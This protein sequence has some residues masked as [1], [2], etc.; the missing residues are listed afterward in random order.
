MHELPLDKQI[1]MKVR[2]LSASYGQRMIIEEICLDIAEREVI[3]LTGSNGSGK[4]T[5]L[6]ALFGLHK[7]I[8][9]GRVEFLSAGKTIK[10][11][12]A[13]VNNHLSLGFAYVPQKEGIFHDLTVGDNFRLSGHQLPP[14]ELERRI[15]IIERWFPW[16]KEY[17]NR[18]PS[19]MSGGECKILAI[20]M[21]LLHQPKLLLIDEPMAGLAGT[22]AKQLSE[23][24][25]D[26]HKAYGTSMLI[27]EH[28]T[29]GLGILNPK[30]IGLKLGRLTNST[31]A[32]IQPS[33]Q[34]NTAT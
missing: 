26:A 14:K 24:L 25:R 22:M 17:W 16:L 33:H 23:V 11:S 2:D 20:T 6:R 19:A 3:L 31:D 21:A 1:L 27:V 34:T 10:I 18:K 29:S 28:R 15:T 7:P 12:E 5:L 30:E 8:Q 4:S 32:S 13:T 9:S